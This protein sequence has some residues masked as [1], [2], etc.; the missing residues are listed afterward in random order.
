MQSRFLEDPPFIK[1]AKPARL[2]GTGLAFL[3]LWLGALQ[4]VCDKGQEDGWFGSSLIRWMAITCIVG[5][6][7]WIVRERFAKS[8]L[9][10]LCIF[11][12]RNFAISC[13]LIGLFGACIYGVV[14]ILPLFYQTLLG[15]NATSA[16][17]AVA[18]RGIGAMFSSV[19][20]G[21]IV[22]R[23]DSR[24]LIALGFVIFGLT[25][26]W[27]ANITLQISFWSLFWPTLI[28]GTALGLI[29]V[30]LSG[31]ALA[32]LPPEQLGNG[33]ALFN[34]IRNIGGSIGISAVNTIAQRRFQAH[35]GELVTS[36]GGTNLAV[37]RYIASLTAAMKSHVGPR[38]AMQR[39]YASLQTTLDSQA[40]LWAY[41]DDF[42]YLA[43]LCG[44][45]VLV[46]MFLKRTKGSA[47]PAG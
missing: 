34:L 2:D 25:A 12:N 28:S 27:T 9:V 22:S 19:V 4:Y 44:G 18:P 20:V 11:L 31:T 16:G 6:I 39:A 13:L 17:L 7:A 23:V 15:Y 14:A 30:P 38:F 5:F 45:C 41:V 37:Q 36:L 47:E 43:L 42:R 8:P 1:N 29:F 40:Q 26:Y 10:D 3:A 32:T 33:S 21:I 35:R 46:V 24:K